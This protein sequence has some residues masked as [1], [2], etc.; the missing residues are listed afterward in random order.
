[1]EQL[2]NGHNGPAI[3]PPKPVAR[4]TGEILLR[5]RPKTYR[6]IVR[7][8]TENVPVLRISKQLRVTEKSVYAIALRES[9]AITERKNEI[10]SML[11]DVSHIGASRMMDKV[12][13][14]QLRDASIATGIAIQRMLELQG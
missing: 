6:E 5:T 3:T 4:Y 9:T 11:S 8:L 10:I 1:M 7:L 12:G 13:K 14:A 2:D